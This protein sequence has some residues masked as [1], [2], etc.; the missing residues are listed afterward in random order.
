MEGIGDEPVLGREPGKLAP[1]IWNGRMWRPDQ[2]CGDKAGNRRT[3]LRGKNLRET[4]MLGAVFP[5]VGRLCLTV[6]VVWGKKLAL[7][8][9]LNHFKDYFWY[10]YQ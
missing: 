2:G 3:D 10:L 7:H 6:G 9:C 5:L 1:G 8:C 4:G